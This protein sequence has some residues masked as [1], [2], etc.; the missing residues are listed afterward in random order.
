MI[1]AYF[2]GVTRS[3]KS[4]FVRIL[5]CLLLAALAFT[6]GGVEAT[7]LADTEPIDKAGV[8]IGVRSV[9]NCRKSVGVWGPTVSFMVRAR[10][11]GKA[12]A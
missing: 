1:F 5:L 10:F 9:C 8:V 4:L 6:T 3:S 11:A 7:E 2:S 12:S